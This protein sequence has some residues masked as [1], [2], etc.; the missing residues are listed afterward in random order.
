MQGNDAAMQSRTASLLK[1]FKTAQVPPRLRRRPSGTLMLDEAVLEDQYSLRRSVLMFVS[2]FGVAL[3]AAGALFVL[4]HERYGL[5]PPR[6]WWLLLTCTNAAL[7]LYALWSW[8]MEEVKGHKAD[9]WLFSLLGTYLWGVAR[10]EVVTTSSAAASSSSSLDAPPRESPPKRPFYPMPPDAWH[11]PWGPCVVVCACYLYRSVWQHCTV[12]RHCM[13]VW[14]RRRLD[15]T[16]WPF[17]ASSLETALSP[18][19]GRLV[20]SVGEYVF[21]TRCMLPNALW[22]RDRWLVMPLTCVVALAEV[23]SDV[24]VIKRHYGFF[25]VENSLWVV[26]PRRP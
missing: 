9:S 21:V 6:A 25:A 4:F 22:G 19:M 18:L 20:A 7:L 15:A 26:R 5:A 8:V 24:G 2:T 23:V 11:C 10:G 16:A 12:E 13:D 3:A 17:A 1:E 14:P